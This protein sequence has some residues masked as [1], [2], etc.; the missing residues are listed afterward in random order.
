[1][2]TKDGR[3]VLEDNACF[4]YA[5]T[6]T[7]FSL[8]GDETDIARLMLAAF[9][10]SA[11]LSMRGGYSAEVFLAAGGYPGNHQTGVAVKVSHCTIPFTKLGP[12]APIC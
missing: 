5:E 1:M 12:R 11:K 2:I 9:L 7:L 3:K 6:G 4:G 10:S 8:I